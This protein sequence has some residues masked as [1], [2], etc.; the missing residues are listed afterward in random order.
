MNFIEN[1]YTWNFN[2]I[3][4]S[5]IILKSS[6]IIPQIKKLNFFFLI[7]QKQYKKNL[8]LF[9]IIVSL[10]FNT[11]L[12]LKNKSLEGVQIFCF[13][14]KKKKI[15]NFLLLFV[16]IYLPLINIPQ[17]IIKKN[18][19]SFPLKKKT[20]LIF[21]LNYFT[22]PS[23]YELDLIYRACEQIQNF[24]NNYRLQLDIFIKTSFYVKHSLD[25]LIRMYRIPYVLKLK[26]KID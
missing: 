23:I 3:T 22:F 15:F 16:N 24:I 25:F 2:A 26:K 17:D 20:L 18:V 6:K 21:R 4:I 13:K 19:L 10:I 5:K 1:Y 14:L 11:V 8:L 7:N 9:Y 12:I